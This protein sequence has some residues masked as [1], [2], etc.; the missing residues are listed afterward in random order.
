MLSLRISRRYP[1]IRRFNNAQS[2][3]SLLANQDGLRCDHAELAIIIVTKYGTTRKLHFFFDSGAD[4]MVIPTYVARHEGIRYREDYPGTIAS[5]VGGSV[6]CYYDF[7]QVRSS[8]SGRTHRWVCAFSE[9]LQG[10]LIVGRAGFLNDFAA[11]VR[12]RHFVVS[13]QVS[14]SRFLKHHAAR[15][16]APAGDE[17]EPI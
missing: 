1:L 13:H 3:R 10:R 7:V 2:L 5:S 4:L 16:R 11:G 9:S 12:G 6:R 15:Q 14:V 17:W 8:L